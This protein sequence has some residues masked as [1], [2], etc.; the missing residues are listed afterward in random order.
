M[1]LSIIIVNWNTKALLKQC[2]E[3]LE[4]GCKGTG[5]YEV[6]IVDNGSTDGSKEYLKSQISNVKTKSQ[7]LKLIFN[8]S[9]LGFARGN[10]V[11]LKKLRVN[12]LCF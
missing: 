9:N 4:G 11:E 3:S 2:L 12:T 7:N 5:E 6:I 1:K 10:N 8:D